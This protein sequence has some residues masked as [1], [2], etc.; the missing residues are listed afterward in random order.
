MQPHGQPHS[1]LVFSGFYLFFC[2][3]HP[4]AGDHGGILLLS[5]YQAESRNTYLSSS[6]TCNWLECSKV[7]FA[8]KLREFFLLNSYWPHPT[9]HVG[10]SFPNQRLNLSS[11]QWKLRAST[12]GLPGN[13]QKS[14]FFKVEERL[15]TNRKGKIKSKHTT[16]PP[17]SPQKI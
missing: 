7:N 13:S 4:P 15:V 6:Q 17:P 8:K 2:G 14:I 10:S 3:C 12:T 11:L 5:L 9:Q 1:I 16:P